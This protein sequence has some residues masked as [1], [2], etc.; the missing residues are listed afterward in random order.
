M[1]HLEQ[2]FLR[3]KVAVLI[4]QGVEDI[5]F[6]V[7]VNGLRQQGIDVIVLSS[8]M[9][10]K[11]KGKRGKL[12]ILSDGTTTE[13]KIEE[14]AGVVIPG[15]IA[16][17]KMRCNRNTVRFVRDAMNLG[18]WV[19]AIG[20]GPQVLIEG[21]L[22]RN[23]HVT[24][25]NSI[26]QDI[27]NAGGRYQDQ[28]IVVDNN[29]ITSREIGDLSIF[30]AGF[31]HRLGYGGERDGFPDESDTKTEWWKLADIWGGSTRGDIAKGLTTAL[32]GGRYLVEALENYAKKELDIEFKLLLQEII[33]VQE[34]HIQK[35]QNYLYKLS[36]KT[37]VTSNV[38]NNYAKIKNALMRNAQTYQIG[39]A[40]SDIQMRMG[41]INNLCGMY[42]DPVATAI[43]KEIY[44]DLEKTE[45]RLLEMYI[46]RTTTELTSDIPAPQ[47][48]LK[49]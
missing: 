31:L 49:I 32:V 6:I 22:L 8:R 25:F 23:K 40:L 16:P 4:E 37:Y 43:F 10:E 14:F 21:D 39:C 11:Y 48:I 5:E 45:Q 42:T 35:L 24:G 13:A 47:P 28:P 19:G 34:I 7:I 44:H 46:S 26:R 20:H 2:N 9:H 12:S 17:D 3:K 18:K 27:I 30:T 41:D 15:G 38:T 1:K 29:L 36:E 33:S